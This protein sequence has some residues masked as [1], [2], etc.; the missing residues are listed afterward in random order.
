MVPS[1]V[2]SVKNTMSSTA[3]VADPG[4]SPRWRRALAVGPAAFLVLVALWE[5][6]AAT[7]AGRDVPPSDAWQR[8][9][10]TVRKEYRP[11][12][13]IVFAPDWIDP[14]GRMHLGDLIPVDVAGA[15]DD[16][17]YRT[18]WELSI[19][20]AESRYSR[21]RQVEWRG[22]FGGVHVRRLVREPAV[23]VTDFLAGLGRVQVSGRARGRPRVVLAEVAFEPHRCV[24][25]EPLPGQ[26]VRIAYPGVRLGTE[27]V[28]YVGLADIFTRRDVRDPGRLEVEIDGRV[29]ARAEFGVDRGWVRFSAPTEPSEAASVVFA[30]TAVGRGAR[31]R[32]IC[33]AAE[34]RE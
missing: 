18:V 1:A 34:A 32:L 26:T 28:G 19:R 11:G 13:R 20:G 4:A 5:V 2:L 17:R 7:T 14:V 3:R 10:A 21:G 33:F 9:S 31:Q 27:L 12:D 30:A 23:V 25:V 29:V 15:M 16:A 8:A 6:W 22:D 24:Q